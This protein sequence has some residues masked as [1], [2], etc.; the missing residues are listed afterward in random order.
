MQ[1]I[2]ARNFTRGRSKPIRAIVIHTMECSENH[3][4][5]EATAAYFTRPDTAS[6]HYCV[7][8]D[9]V[10]QC[11]QLGDT[12]W[13]AAGGNSD[14]I[15]IEHAGRAGQGPAEWADD[16]SVRMLRNQSAPLV[17]SLC[18]QF[19][20]PIRKISPEEYNAGARG[21][22]GH[23]DITRAK[24][25]RGGHWDP[26]PSFPWDQYLSWVATAAG[27]VKPVAP[28]PNPVDLGAI[29]RYIAHWRD[30]IS[31]HPVRMGA[32]GEAVV[33]IQKCL[34]NKG[35]RV[36]V[37]GAWGPQ[38]DGAVRAFQRS[39]GLVADGIVGRATMRALL[40]P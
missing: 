29:L 24:N 14:T 37:D 16:Y 31:A 26:G 28:T 1:Y 40:A 9:S 30:Q 34:R 10:V 12:A 22:L 32:R 36:S 13:H 2:Q 21:I 33:F 27:I 18:Q 15:G 35:F 17:A 5:A 7:D 23:I 25:I 20:I 4:S 11:V 8:D 6:A 38:T 3:N 39:R 19:A